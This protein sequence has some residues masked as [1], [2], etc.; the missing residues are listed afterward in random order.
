[1]LA[2]QLGA[3]PASAL[4]ATA[5]LLCSR[6]WTFYLADPWLSDPAALLL[7]AA[8]FVALGADRLRALAAILVPLAGTREIFAGL[9][10]PAWAWLRRRLGGRTAAGAVALVMLPGCLVWA[11]IVATVPSTGLAGFGRLSAPVVAEVWRTRVTADGWRWAANAFA[12]S[13]GSWWVL[14]AASWR[15]PRVRSLAWWLPAVFGQCLLGADWSRFALYAFCVVIPAAAVTLE[16]APRRGPLLALLGAQAAV[17]LLDVLAGQP[18]L[19]H[20]GP[21]LA[22]TVALMVTT[23]AVL[24]VPAAGGGRPRGGR[25]VAARA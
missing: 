6:G 16:R 9:A 18:A 4:I 14:A 11:W 12:M 7:A 21:S 15:D 1:V 22:V 10:L 19:N 13:L 3:S 17:P 5:G 8:A 23:A 20:P 24:L 25:R 2:R